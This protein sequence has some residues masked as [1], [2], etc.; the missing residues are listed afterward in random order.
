L[1]QTTFLNSRFS[2]VRISDIQVK[3]GAI[4]FLV[5]MSSW[6]M[7]HAVVTRGDLL[8]AP[9]TISPPHLLGMRFH[10]PFSKEDTML[11]VLFGTFWLLIILSCFVFIGEAQDD[12]P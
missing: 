3:E 1:T 11:S 4:A 2:D 10:S 8:H 6:L 7:A 12:T 9:P 5:F